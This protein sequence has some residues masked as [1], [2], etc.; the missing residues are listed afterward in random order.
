[1]IGSRLDSDTSTTKSSFD[2]RAWLTMNREPPAKSKSPH[3]KV[4]V[5]PEKHEP[6]TNNKRCMVLFK[7][8]TELLFRSKSEGMVVATSR[9][10][11]WVREK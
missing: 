3:N 6:F 1:M 7:K 4:I 11:F 2:H 8:V 10:Y 5:A 9:N